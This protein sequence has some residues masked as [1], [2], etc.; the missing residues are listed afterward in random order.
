MRRAVVVS[1]VVAI[2]A[3]FP[4][5]GNAAAWKGV[6]VAKDQGRSA[7]VT[8]SRSGVVRTVRL[9]KGLR[10]LKLG[11]RVAVHARSL[12]DGTFSARTVRVLGRVSSARIR[13][14]VVQA[15][16]LRTTVSAGGT[17]FALRGQGAAR[18]LE[19]AEDE[20]EPGDQIVADVS[21]DGGSL[22]V[23]EL[24]EV[25]HTDS[26]K[27]EG[28]FVSLTDGV[29]ELRVGDD[30]VHVT[31]PDGVLLPDLTPGAEISLRASVGENGG[32]TAKEVWLDEDP[33]AQPGEGEPQEDEAN[34][35]GPGEGAGSDEPGDAEDEESESEE[36]GAEGEHPGSGEHADHETEH[37]GDGEQADEP[38]H[39][40]GDGED[41]GEQAD[42][43]GED[44]GEPGA[45][46]GGADGGD[47]PE[48]EGADGPE[49]EGGGPE[50]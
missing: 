22:E 2:A 45:E 5:A 23:E 25:G 6:V 29:L 20:L 33:P 4:I 8:A 19:S 44:D 12:S 26:V 34:G 39:E 7:V 3:A 18:R 35:G 36:H 43:P 38:G 41:S 10:A 15:K 14:I 48:G 28:H 31:I 11:Q 50:V 30:V 9:T 42:E 47:E 32:F 24:E 49:G 37:E 13:A 1:V 46:E 21:V 27:L 16:A 40:E 17:V